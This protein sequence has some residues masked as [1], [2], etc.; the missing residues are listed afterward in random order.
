M[1][2]GQYQ[3]LE[4]LKQRGPVVT[5]RAWDEEQDRGVILKIL[6][7]DAVSSALVDS[8]R[9][10]YALIQ[11]I[12]SPRVLAAYDLVWDDDCPA[13]VLQ[14]LGGQ[15]LADMLGKGKLDVV[16]GLRLAIAAAQALE[17]VHDADIMHGD[18]NPSNLIVG[19]T[20]D[21]VVVIDFGFSE[22][23]GLPAG[24]GAGLRGS[25]DY[26]APEM[27][28][29]LSRGADH[30][31]DLYSLGVL[32]YQMLTGTVP[33]SSGDLLQSVYAH[34]ALQPRPLRDLAPTVPDVVAEVVARLMAKE[35]ELR[36]QTA[37]GLIT[38][39]RH[40]LALVNGEHDVSAFELGQNDVPRR[41]SVSALMHGRHV[42]TQILRDAFDGVRAGATSG[43]TV[44]VLGGAGVGKT[45]LVDSLFTYVGR[46]GGLFVKGRVDAGAWDDPI[47][48]L[49]QA[50]RRLAELLLTERYG[51]LQDWQDRLKTGLGDLLPVLAA[52][53]PEIAAL[54]GNTGPAPKV[55]PRENAERL[56]I[57]FR[58][59]FRVCATSEHPLVLVFEDVHAA[60]AATLAI[61][62]GLTRVNG[63]ERM[64]V[65][66]TCRTEPN[67]TPRADVNID[68]TFV[69]SDLQV[70][71]ITQLLTETLRLPAETTK[72]LAMALVSKVGGAPLAIGQIIGALV[73]ESIIKFDIDENRW[74]WDIGA[75][76][77]REASDDVVEILLQRGARLSPAE[78]A[79]IGA[80]ACIGREF[81]LAQAELAADKAGDDVRGPLEHALSMGWVVPVLALHD[82]VGIPV[83]RF[84]HDRIWLAATTMQDPEDRR[85][86][87]ARLAAQLLAEA[88]GPPQGEAA[89]DVARHL[90]EALGPHS[91][92]AEI[93]QTR[94]LNAS[95][96]A[97]A[98]AVGDLPRSHSC[99][100]TAADLLT[101]QDWQRTLGEALGITAGAAGAALLVGAFDE[102]EVRSN[103]FLAHCPDPVG[104]AG[105]QALNVFCNLAQ[106]RPFEAV[107]VGRV[108]LADL[109]DPLP[110]NP[111]PSEIEAE[112]GS[113]FAAL[114]GRPI[115]DLVTLP[116]VS[117]PAQAAVQ[118]LLAATLFPSFSSNP[119]MFA[120]CAAR[121]AARSV[122]HGLT[123]HSVVGFNDVGLVACGPMNQVDMGYAF[124]QLAQQLVKEKNLVGL[125][126]RVEAIFNAFIR[127][128]KE[129]IRATLPGLIAAR[130]AG[131]SCGDVFSAALASFDHGFQVFWIGERLDD[132]EDALADAHVFCADLNV[133]LMH[134]LI[135]IYRQTSV[136]LHDGADTP[137]LLSGDCANG[138]DLLD[139]FGEQQNLNGL[140]QLHICQML[141]AHVYGRREARCAMS[142]GHC[143]HPRITC[144]LCHICNDCGARCRRRCAD[145]RRYG[146]S[147]S[148]RRTYRI[149]GV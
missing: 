42:E 43:V 2:F 69:L 72:P 144:V 46:D 132:A 142:A 120:T 146:N 118:E 68:H 18:I 110:A 109:N 28:G 39:L 52:L 11:E 58:Q 133:G 137:E 124:S 114:A 14:D 8:L 24:Q 87:H 117:D 95:A 56:G 9:R 82:A 77:A 16:V 88:K 59:F 116:D 27:T 53:A 70:E 7:K 149:L 85:A 84:S 45:T 86:T 145:R 29:R 49:V 55:S 26:I 102:V 80:V 32:I 115:E 6:Q 15:V 90:K 67:E 123:E 40:C 51:S 23:G 126:P 34:M 22:R 19:D 1:R 101:E 107:E 81:T 130:D 140:A 148:G 36:Y 75:V 10:E 119:M 41:L 113:I 25:P 63:S 135:N 121:L 4:T 83:L 64:L 127:H 112:I 139:I 21:D 20:P 17:A 37:A 99:M 97:Q 65:I 50:A 91:S 96:G 100:Q 134:D 141:L 111:G 66:Q 104:R 44:R 129:P 125:R 136:A 94:G 106:N 57:A 60:D 3:I 62:D 78:R 12:K 89:F 108:A 143:Q 47:G 13:L 76:M 71:D 30:R 73:D 98:I 128:R 35:P 103:T 74:A 61:L 5:C 33:F 105:V 147:S 48:G 122:A 93:G 131:T 92:P 138:A 54:A 79:V 38:D 31:S